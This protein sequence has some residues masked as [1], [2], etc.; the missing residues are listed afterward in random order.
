MAW[1]KFA[2]AESQTNILNW[3]TDVYPTIESWPSFIC[4]DKAC[5]IMKTAVTNKSW[6]I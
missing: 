2:A 3:L 5:L 4:I 6:D 1:T